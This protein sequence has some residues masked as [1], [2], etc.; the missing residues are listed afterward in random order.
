M[1]VTEHAAFRRV[2][3]TGVIYVTVEA[4]KR[5]FGADAADW[6]NLG[7]GQP[8]TGELEG[9]PARIQQID[10]RP[11]DL[12]YA[13]VPGLFELRESVADLY[14]RLFRRGMKSQYSAENV[15]I[16]GG[17]RVGITRALSLIHI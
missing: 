2:P 9:A 13:P 8:D 15:A 1:E 11:E 7:Q 5:G 3:R 17:G 6:C 12:D 4:Q 16:A 10:V 14:N